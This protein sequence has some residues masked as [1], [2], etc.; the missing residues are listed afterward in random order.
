MVR[1]A[2]RDG[3]P[4]AVALLLLALKVR[5]NKRTRR[6]FAAVRRA[7]NDPVQPRW[8]TVLQK[9]VWRLYGLLKSMS[10]PRGRH[11]TERLPLSRAQPELQL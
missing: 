1:K 6:N 3:E 8:F 2:V 9:Q 11:A 4:G 5:C 7:F 10:L